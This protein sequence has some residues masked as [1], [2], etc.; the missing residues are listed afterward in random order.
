MNHDFLRCTLPPEVKPPVKCPP[1]I[2]GTHRRRGNS[3]PPGCGIKS[4]SRKEEKYKL[5]GQ[6]TPEKLL[7]VYRDSLLMELKN[8]SIIEYNIFRKTRY[9]FSPS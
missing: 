9:G 1:H 2:N 3:D 7:K 6:Y 8:Y 4:S 5:S